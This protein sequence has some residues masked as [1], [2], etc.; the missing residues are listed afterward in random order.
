MG[1]LA[2]R[3][4]TDVDLL[5]EDGVVED[6]PARAAVSTL[7]DRTARDR[8]TADALRAYLQTARPDA[9]RLVDVRL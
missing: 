1:E 3:W 8:A 4:S 2:H 5:V 9:A 6:E 7:R